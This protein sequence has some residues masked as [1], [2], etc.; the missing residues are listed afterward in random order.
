MSSGKQWLASARGAWHLRHAELEVTACYTQLP[1]DP[2][3]CSELPS[4]DRANWREKVCWACA[5]V[6]GIHTG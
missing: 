1:S 2:R 6:A 5:R 4:E 3:V